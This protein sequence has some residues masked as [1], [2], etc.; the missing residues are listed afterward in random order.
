[1]RTPFQLESSYAT[2]AVHFP[3]MHLSNYSK[4]KVQAIPIEC[5]IEVFRR[6][7]PSGI[8]I[9]KIFRCFKKEQLDYLHKLIPINHSLRDILQIT[10]NGFAYKMVE[11]SGGA[12]LDHPLFNPN[13]GFFTYYIAVLARDKKDGIHG[14]K[15]SIDAVKEK[16]DRLMALPSFDFSQNI[17]CLEISPSEF[18]ERKAVQDSI[19]I[20][21]I[22]SMIDPSPET[23]RLI[24][25]TALC[26]RQSTI[27]EFLISNNMIDIDAEYDFK[28]IGSGSD[29]LGMLYQYTYKDRIYLIH[30]IY[31]NPRT[32]NRMS[33]RHYYSPETH[34]F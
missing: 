17:G 33:F 3:K 5:A 22:Q 13:L 19:Y 11:G 32:E 14:T 6:E 4:K 20:K 34:P 25:M 24:Y 30:R 1:M 23:L 29:A 2:F 10:V 28:K 27:I 7:L 18:P 21:G 31:S 16:I 9:R 12:I 8:L 15:L 26:A